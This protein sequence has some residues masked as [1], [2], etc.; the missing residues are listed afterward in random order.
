MKVIYVLAWMFLGMAVMFRI[1]PYIYM[2]ENSVR[3][4]TVLVYIPVDKAL[5]RR[6]RRGYLRRYL[7]KL[8]IVVLIFQQIGA[9]I[10]GCWSV[11]NLIYPVALICFLYLEGLAYIGKK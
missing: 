5:L 6:V 1:Q 4:S 9:L 8:G 2:I 3:I 11:W 7:I 10:D